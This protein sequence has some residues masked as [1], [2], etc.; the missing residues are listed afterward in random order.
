[1]VGLSWGDVS[2]ISPS[3]AATLCMALVL[4]IVIPRLVRPFFIDRMLNINWLAACKLFFVVLWI[5][6]SVI[7]M[8]QN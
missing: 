5:L 1:M 4:A 7:S 8:L 6:L 3:D 2:A